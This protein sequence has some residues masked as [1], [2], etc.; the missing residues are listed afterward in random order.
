MTARAGDRL[1]LL[2]LFLVPLLL[3]GRACAPGQVL[4]PRHPVRFAP[5]DR[6][7][8]P[9]FLEEVSRG[10]N[11]VMIDKV[12]PILTDARAFVRGIREGRVPLWDPRD[13]GGSPLL[14]QSVAGSLYPP[15]LLGHL[16]L[17]PEKAFA[18]LAI[19]SLF[20]AGGFAFL[21]LR[22]RAL[23]AAPALLGALAFA[24]SG[25]CLANLH[26]PCKV[27]ALVWLPAAFLAV[28][29][30]AQGPRPGPAAGL[31]A[32]LGLSG[33]AGFPQVSAYVVL[34]T[35]A[36]AAVRLTRV[37]PEARARTLLLAGGA[38]I[39]GLALA[40]VQLLPAAEASRESLR[41]L[42]TVESFRSSSLETPLLTHFLLP[43]AF[44]SPTEP[45]S[46]RLEPFAWLLL[47]RPTV[48]D[49]RFLFTEGALYLGIAPL[50]LLLAGLLRREGRFPAAGFIASL[51]FAFGSPLLAPLTWTPIAR[52]GVP[53]RAFAVGT[54]F[55]A[56]LVALGVDRVLRPENSALRRSLAGCALLLVL[57]G[58]AGALAIRP[59]R[60][61]AGA[62]PRLVERWRGSPEAARIEPLDEAKVRS[63]F[64]PAV[65]EQ[66]GR[67][68]RGD[69]LRLAIFAALSGGALLAGRN[70]PIA[71]AA[72][73]IAD[74]LSLGWPILAPRRAGALFPECP[75]VSA[76]RAAAGD[77]RV[78]RCDPTPGGEPA[79]V[80]NLLRSNL[81][82]EYGISDLS[83]HMAFAPR[84]PIELFEALDPATR[85]R[86]WLA[87]LTDPAQV[88]EPL[89]DAA[90][91]GAVLSAEAIG[92]PRLEETYREEGFHVYRRRDAL[93]RAWVVPRGRFVR[94]DGRPGPGNE[95]IP[96][97]L[98]RSFHPREEVVLPE[99]ASRS[100][101]TGGG[102]VRL[103]AVSAERL[104]VAVRGTGG[105]YLV[106]SEV[107]YPGWTATLDGKPVAV[108]RANY[109]W[110][111]V[112]LPPGDHDVVFFY[113]PRSLSIGL[114]ASA[115]GG[116]FVLACLG[117]RLRPRRS[118]SSAA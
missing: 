91:V 111:A 23:P 108:E 33:L 88:G 15:N 116:L 93:P 10:E 84:R 8:D 64:P 114:A 36:Y 79:L 57:F 18:P 20:L 58:G 66:A 46:G 101:G 24:L 13:A 89:L 44:A 4:L 115:A 38:G 63:L 30:L 34:A 106:T 76:T 65:F 95:A 85:Y 109:A 113:S 100:T 87:R 17:G 1:A 42:Q 99:S 56:W 117:L 81:L 90:G 55:A 74:L 43:H 110:R 96:A 3:L 51:L 103:R 78:V 83:G 16:L 105:G 5:L 26:Y 92:D 47:Q 82:G 70:R 72:V 22:A 53:A 68:L 52:V 54:F 73:S 27:D 112:A 94:D 77:L 97:V 31:A 28:E 50:L 6:H 7:V 9:A 49:S 75:P 45:P 102:E 35:A 80:Y 25:H 21:F 29:R 86:D 69:L 104:E 62:V 39:A 12:L 107:F 71:L 118:R 32:S 40:G 19:L 2:V 67:R 60:I 14:A 61:E 98:S 59:A 37:A 41:S 48:A 11:P